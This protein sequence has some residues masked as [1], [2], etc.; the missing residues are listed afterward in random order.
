MGEFS[1]LIEV[2]KHASQDFEAKV[3]LVSQAVSPSL[4]D[5]DLVVQAFDKAKGDFVLRLAV[6]GDAFPVTL[7]H[8]GEFFKRLQALPLQGSL[9][10]VE[11]FPGASFV[12]VVPE[13]AE[14]FFE[15]VGGVKP[16]VGRQ[17]VFESVAA[18]A[19]KVL[20]VG[21]QVVFLPLDEAPVLA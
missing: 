17:E 6:S 10:G 19:F 20:P 9:P 2:R 7:D 5:P 11:E 14:L 15:K 13:P 21:Q 3:F 18:V 12:A 8:P 16:L 4:N 1:C